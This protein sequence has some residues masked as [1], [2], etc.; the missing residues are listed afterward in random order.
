MTRD[1]F[2]EIHHAKAILMTASNS[3]YALANSL[4]SGHDGVKCGC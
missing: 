2:G 4:N 3:L 1:S